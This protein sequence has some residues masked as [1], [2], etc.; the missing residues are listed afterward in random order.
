MVSRLHAQ[1]T[2]RTFNIPAGAAESSL[3]AFAEQSGVQFIFSANK[4]KGAHTNAVQGRHLPR[5]ALEIMTAGTELR[6]VRDERTGALTVDRT[7]AVAV[8]QPQAAT[9]AAGPSSE[10]TVRLP[11]FSVSAQQE[12]P[13]RA[14]SSVSAARVR[15]EINETPASINVIT[16]EFMD[17]LAPTRLYDATRYVAGITEGRGPTFQDRVQIR[18]FEN[19]NRTIDNFLL[20]ANSNFDEA[21]VDR[22]EIVKGPNTILAPTGSPGG[23]VNVITKSPLFTPRQEISAMVGVYDAQRI[24]IDSTGPLPGSGKFAY[25]AI[26]A[27]QDTD[28]NWDDS[29]LRVRLINPQLTFQPSD[30][31]NVTLKYYYS[32]SASWG[33]PRVLVDSS[34]T[35]GATVVKAPG[36]SRSGRN[37]AEDWNT[38]TTTLHKVNL[39]FNTALSDH[40]S[41]RLAADY[42]WV[43]EF[44][45]LSQLN[46]P[47]TSNRYNPYTGQLTPDTI[48]TAPAGT[49]D[50]APVP[51]PFYDPTNIPRISALAIGSS[52]TFSVQNDYAATYN[53]ERVSS[54]T[55]AGW[56]FTHA[57]SD[58]H[59]KTGTLPSF[60]LF[61]PV[62]GARPVYPDNL[63]T[64]TSER[65]DP[66][67]LYVMEK[68]AF[69]DN[70]IIATGGASRVWVKSTSSNLLAGTSGKLDDYQDT[71]F[72][73]ILAKAFGAS[74]YYSYSTNA[75]ASTLNNQPVWSTGVQHEFGVKADLLNRKL[76]LTLAHFDITQDNVVV[77][78][79]EFQVDKTVPQFLRYDL[80]SDGWEFEAMGTLTSN[81]SLV[82]SLTLMRARDSFGRRLRAISDHAAALL[83]NYKFTDSRLK[84]LSL[85]LGAS[86]TGSQAVDAPPPV[87]VLGVVA[88]PSAYVEGY[89]TVTANV[90]YRWKNYTVRLTGDNILDD[91]Y[92]YSPGARFAVAQA[93]RPNV[94]LTFTTRF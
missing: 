23:A 20:S 68:L 8:V 16:R 56:V 4:V 46:Y 76:S 34:V 7:L 50:Y 26:G 27:Y 71:Y 40:I 10:D 83:V 84:G 94:R 70:R 85:S 87:T 18:G 80:K 72:G 45:E 17:D 53:F 15:G 55:V 22:V 59:T 73:G 86:Y 6:V 64:N 12:S 93:P 78:N 82:G 13:Y 25:R 38:R 61:A 89:T 32:D 28:R 57:W 31:T 47:N 79:P 62:Y 74:Y 3:P 35:D 65:S 75:N 1:E 60:N 44:G 43:R 33:D 14:G 24:S 2:Q 36:Y 19:N 5:E 29:S 91:D 67:Q 66:R 63:T 77:P 11:V 39:Q 88:Q 49:L 30:R 52:Q 42:T 69:L 54:T 9:P 90:S 58:G 37:G 51:S 92:L 41:V 81:W 21:L 48:W